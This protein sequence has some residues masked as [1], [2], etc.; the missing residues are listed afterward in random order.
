MQKRH[1]KKSINR[2]F[3]MGCGLD[4]DRLAEY[5]YM[6]RDSIWFSVA[7][8]KHGYLCIGCLEKRL[9]RR[10]V[11]EDFSDVLINKLD[12]WRKSMRLRSRLGTLGGV[13]WIKR[14]SRGIVHAK[15][16]SENPADQLHVRSDASF[17]VH[18]V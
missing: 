8:T 13:E 1:C 12:R 15:K 18:A 14:K 2:I 3:C 10:L 16:I 11:V 17:Q 7:E 9:G 5:A 6:V 4:I